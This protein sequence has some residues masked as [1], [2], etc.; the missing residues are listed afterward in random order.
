MRGNTNVH[1]VWI[2]FRSQPSRRLLPRPVHRRPQD[3][4][5]HRIPVVSAVFFFFPCSSFHGRTAR[6]PPPQSNTGMDLS[7]DR[8]SKNV[9][10]TLN[11]QLRDDPYREILGAAC[12]ATTCQPF[13]PPMWE[14][15]GESAG[16]WMSLDVSALW[17]KKKQYQRSRLWKRFSG[18]RQ[19]L[20]VATGGEH[21][22]KT[23]QTERGL[24]GANEG[25]RVQHR[26]GFETI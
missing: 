14:I 17:D 6:R 8:P 10:L 4:S 21:P 3:G 25:W 20:S 11:F 13:S 23:R 9:Q 1:L 19:A 22:S 7:S 12:G 16:F 26:L 24:A 18:R 15:T 2:S 5:D